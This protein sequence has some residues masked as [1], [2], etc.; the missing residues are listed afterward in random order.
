MFEI[1]P[2][3]H[4]I[5]VHFTVALLSI[6]VALFILAFVVK[7][8]AWTPSVLTTAHW[9]LWLGA[10]LT[11]MTIAA[12]LYAYNTVAH[13]DPSHAAMTEHRNWAFATAALFWSLALIAAWRKKQRR[14]VGVLFVAA[15]VLSSGVLLTTAWK[16]GELV[17][18]HGLGVMSLP[19]SE[20]EG[21]EHTEGQNHMDDSGD[22]QDK[23]H[24][25]DDDHDH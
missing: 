6:S 16:G 19:Q 7:E 17:F 13:D 12:G 18:R 5:F 20:G 23:G 3:W 11:V 2:N 21:H 1:L 10:A 15:L 14:E 4:P 8:K 22:D 25:H 9:N 24:D